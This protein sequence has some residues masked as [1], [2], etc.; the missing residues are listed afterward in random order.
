M[1]H[2]PQADNN[3]NNSRNIQPSYWG[4]TRGTHYITAQPKF[5]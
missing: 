4:K 1:A 3:R 2:K 5:C